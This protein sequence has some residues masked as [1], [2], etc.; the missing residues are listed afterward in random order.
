MSAVVIVDHTAQ[1]FPPTQ[2]SSLDWLFF[3]QRQRRSLA[4]TLMWTPLAVILYMFN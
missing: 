3:C 1:H 4:D 2:S